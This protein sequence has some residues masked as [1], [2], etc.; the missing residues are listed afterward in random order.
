MDSWFGVV[1]WRPAPQGPE[2]QN[3]IP[4]HQ[5]KPQTFGLPDQKPLSKP[6]SYGSPEYGT[7]LIPFLGVPELGCPLLKSPAKPPKLLSRVPVGNPAAKPSKKQKKKK[8]LRSRTAV[9]AKLRMPTA[10][11]RIERGPRLRLARRGLP[12]TAYMPRLRFP[13]LLR[14]SP[15]SCGQGHASLAELSAGDPGDREPQLSRGDPSE[16]KKKKQSGVPSHQVHMEPY[17]T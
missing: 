17:G 4:N 15:G 1:P 2:V 3:Q 8:T 10:P 5:S 6:P 14:P 13:F 7:H 16:E 12:P 9:L 11:R